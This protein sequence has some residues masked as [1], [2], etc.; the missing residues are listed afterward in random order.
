[1]T[2]EEFWKEFMAGEILVN[3]TTMN[4]CEM[5]IKMC[6]KDD[7]SAVGDISKYFSY[8]EKSCIGTANDANGLPL[9]LVYGN[10]DQLKINGIKIVRFDEIFGEKED[11][12]ERKCIAHLNVK[13]YDDGTLVPDVF[14]SDRQ[15]A[16]F[17][18]LMIG[19]ITKKTSMSRE[20]IYSLLD[21]VLANE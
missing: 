7:I 13:F 8:G 12:K 6:E 11:T 3:T 5:F 16:A 17:V 4:Q 21:T 2:K 9:W 1:M 10:L 19:Y 15:I 20:D 18:L 14:A